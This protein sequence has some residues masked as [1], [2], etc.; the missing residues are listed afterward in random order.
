MRIPAHY[1]SCDFLT[2]RKIN[3]VFYRS[4]VQ[5]FTTQ[6]MAM[7]A[8]MVV[9]TTLSIATVK[10]ATPAATEYANHTV[11]GVA[12]WLF[13]DTASTSYANYSS[14]AA[15]QTFNRGD[16][17]IFYTSANETVIQ[18]YNKTTYQSCSTVDA[19]INSDTFQYHAGGD[20]FGSLETIVGP[21]TIQGPNYFFSDADD[22][23]QCEHGMAFEIIV[24]HGL[25][26]PASLNQPPPQPYVAPLSP[27]SPPDAQLPLITVL[28][29]TSEGFRACDG[30]LVLCF[31]PVVLFLRLFSP[32]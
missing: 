25:G 21:L 30:L 6:A 26:L 8:T 20:L 2:D 9:I 4:E 13:N 16:Y 14:W 10:S 18:T 1:V 5:R 19:L 22:G 15:N 29:P 32:K 17:L 24:D 28:Q 27:V 7:A 23:V 11:G 3:A 12:G 31:W